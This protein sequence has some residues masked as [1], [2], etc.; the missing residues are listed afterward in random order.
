[1]S[2]SGDN[3]YASPEGTN[4]E[5]QQP[6]GSEAVVPRTSVD[7]METLGDVFNN[8]NWFVNILL[9]GI[10]IIIPII[11]GM[12]ALGYVAEIIGARA[13][14]RIKTY[15]DFDFNRFV[16]YLTRGFWMF[17]VTFLTSLCLAPLGMVAGGIMG[18]LSATEN[19]VLV[20]I[21]FVI[22]FFSIF[23]INLLSFFLMCPLVIRAGMLNDFAGAFD[24]GWIMDFIKKMWVEQLI[25][26]ILLYIFA[27]FIMLVGCMALCVGYIPAAGVVVIM[28]SLFITQLYQVYIH[29]GGQGLPFKEAKKL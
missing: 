22:Y 26:G 3:P 13:Y 21:G 17:L 25:G 19:E 11:G 23:A 10:A 8:P 29:R 27:M 18:A 12:V 15:P 16:E 2:T 24:F 6:T 5:P 28:S 20:L 1:M 4:Y 14:G 7:Y 9:A